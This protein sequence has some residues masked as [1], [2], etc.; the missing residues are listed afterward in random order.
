MTEEHL[1]NEVIHLVK[2]GKKPDGSVLNFTDIQ[3]I[4]KKKYPNIEVKTINLVIDSIYIDPKI[5]WFFTLDDFKNSS[6][7][8]DVWI[9]LIRSRIYREYSLFYSNFKI[10]KNIEKMKDLKLLIEKNKIISVC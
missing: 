5:R 10:Q 2:N 3:N 6:N 8:E 9:T 1:I 7:T 4:C